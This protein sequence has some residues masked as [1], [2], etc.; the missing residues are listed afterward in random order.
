[1]AEPAEATTSSAI[2]FPPLNR[3]QTTLIEAVL[4]K[5]APRLIDVEGAIRVGKSW[6]AVILVWLLALLFPGIRILLARWKQEDAD[7]QLV[8]VWQAVAAFFPKRLHPVWIPNLHAYKFANGSVVYRHGL[9]AG[10][11]EARNS[12]WRGKTLAVIV[13]DQAEEMP[14]WAF[15]DLQGRLSQ[16][17][18]PD[19]LQPFDYPLHLILVPNSVDEDHWIAQE[20]PSDNRLPGRWYL[21]GNL[22]DNAENLGEKVVAGLD[23]A[24][25]E[26]DPQR[27]T[28]LEGK[29]GPTLTGKPVYGGKHGAFKRAIHVSDKARA[30]AY[31]PILVGLDFGEEKPG[32]VFAQYI[33][34]IGAFR[35]LGAIKG[36]HV[37]LEDLVPKY[38]EIRQRW[39]PGFEVMPWCDPTG[40]K[41]NGGMLQTPVRLLHSL[42]VPAR[43]D[44]NANDAEVR[45]GAIQ[46]MSSFMRRTAAD[47]SPAFLMHPRCIEISWSDAG[48]LVER[49]TSLMVTAFMTGYVWGESAPSDSN[50]NIRKPKKGTRYDDLMN[51]CEYIVI[52]ERLGAPL[53][54]QEREAEKRRLQREGAA[55]G[56][57]LRAEQGKETLV[58]AMARIAQENRQFRDDDPSDRLHGKGRYRYRGGGYSIGSRG[59]WRKG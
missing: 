5:R 45:Y 19:T 58:E 2:P 24:Y 49:E 4:E 55:Q 40:A 17:A 10:E 30:N 23:E 31:Y 48:E 51:A 3:V 37:V 27:I 15:A 41:G 14:D 53:S 34:Y 22:W 20:F 36:S 1:M 33:R 52:G 32:I 18:N 35:I 46:T 29:R 50:P 59:G 28:L 57:A 38:D 9:R 11:L 13:I 43:Y 7:G 54:S 39:F 44:G 56:R 26:G 42:G 25:P 16:S 21:S 47:G 6:G 12:K 8:E